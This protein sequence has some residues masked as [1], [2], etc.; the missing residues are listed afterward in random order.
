MTTTQTTKATK[1]VKLTK[2]ERASLTEKLSHARLMLDTQA[3]NARY[4]AAYARMLFTRGI[5]PEAELHNMRLDR[6][7]ARAWR[8]EV[9]RMEAL[10]G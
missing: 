2:R 10:L 1:A 7:I 6:D 4:W 8:A 9:K 5:V 3:G